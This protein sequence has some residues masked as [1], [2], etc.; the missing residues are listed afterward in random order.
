[1]RRPP[2]ALTVALLLAPLTLPPA[3]SGAAVAAVR[4][5]NDK[6]GQIRH[7]INRFERLRRAGDQVMVDGDC[8]SACTLVLGLV[9]HDRL[10]VTPRARFGFHRAWKPG[11]FGLH[12]DN[13]AGTRILWR[14]YPTKIRNWI[15][16]QGGLSDN[17][18][19]LAG[20]QLRAFYPLCR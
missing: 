20:H 10:C 17:F 19:Y 5:G 15:A 12:L 14:L 6:G 18:L 4:I 9:P 2:L 11:I 8:M 1:M 7:Y 3:A 13:A 16:A